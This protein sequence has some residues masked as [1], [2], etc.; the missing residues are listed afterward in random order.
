MSL[1]SLDMRHTTLVLIDLQRGVVNLPTLPRSGAEVIQ[2]AV[3]LVERFRET[4]APVVLVRVAFS[5]DGAAMG[6]SLRADSR[7]VVIIQYA[8]LLLIL[9]SLALVTP[10]LSHHSSPP[11]VQVEVTTAVLPAIFVWW[12]IGV[13]CLLAFIGWLTGM[14]TRIPAG[15][16][17]VPTVLYFFLEISGFNWAV[18][19]GRSL[20]LPSIFSAERRTVNAER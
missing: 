17:L 19:L 16:F 8:R 1:S 4:E 14:R 5:P 12:K 6:D 7:L 15:T 9:A 2:N 10:F 20:P 18:G 3:R 13:L 11:R